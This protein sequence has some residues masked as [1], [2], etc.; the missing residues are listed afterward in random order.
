MK[1]DGGFQ[2]LFSG[3]CCWHTLLVDILLFDLF[4]TG[5]LHLR[6]CTLSTTQLFKSLTGIVFTRGYNTPWPCGESTKT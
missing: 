1:V 3:S 5:K 6:S 4:L 2:I